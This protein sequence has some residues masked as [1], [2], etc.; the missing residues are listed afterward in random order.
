[1]ASKQGVHIL[2]EAAKM[3]NLPENETFGVLMTQ[4]PL[5]VHLGMIKNGLCGWLSRHVCMKLRVLSSRGGD[6]D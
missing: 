5:K 4:H 1:M 3:V 6:E 2:R